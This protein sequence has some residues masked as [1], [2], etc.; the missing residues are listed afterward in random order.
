MIEIL[1]S[2]S[3]IALGA[4][5]ALLGPVAIAVWIVA[6]GEARR[7]GWVALMVGAALLIAGPWHVA[8]ALE[9]GAVLP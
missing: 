8:M 6:I 7:L 5:I 9:H 3:L 1:E 4:A 2:A